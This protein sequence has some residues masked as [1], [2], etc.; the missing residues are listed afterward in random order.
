[1]VDKAFDDL[2]AA[3]EMTGADTLAIL[4]GVNSREASFTLAARF[5]RGNQI[6][7]QTG[8][9]YT[10]VLN[11]SGLSVRMNNAS[12]NTLT[13]PPNSSVAYPIG[14]RIL[15]TQIGAGTTTVVEGS[16]VTINTEV[17]LIIGTQ[18]KSALVTKVA[19]DV[20]DMAKG[21]AGATK[22]NDLTDVDVT[23]RTP[24]KQD[25]LAFDGTNWVPVGASICILK[26]K[27]ESY[28]SGTAKVIAWTEV[29]D[30]DSYF[31]GGTVADEQWVFPF[32]GRYRIS[33]KI[34]V[35]N[36]AHTIWEWSVW[37]RKDRGA[38]TTEDNDHP[39][40]RREGKR[41]LTSLS[42]GEAVFANAII[43]ATA[44]DEMDLLFKH[45]SVTRDMIENA[46]YCYIE[47][48]GETP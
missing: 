38:T 7:D 43:D 22:L 29:E 34:G 9:S 23:T 17:D 3:A 31:G 21:G 37:C 42:L 20:W 1:M 10:T 12:A 28:V 36:V 48:M 5:M 13:I 41:S 8:T 19:T 2:T 33:Y 47:F 26:A 46:T 39:K 24:A 6:N 35:I 40:L 30:T 14:T 27:I 32:T 15:I 44:N 4:F 11:D 25:R 16:G 45:T 18:W